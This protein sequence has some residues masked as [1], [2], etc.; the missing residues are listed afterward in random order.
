MK[1]AIQGVKAS[2]H[3]VAA[4]TYFKQTIEPLECATFREL[5]E[6]LKAKKCEFALMAIEN[7]I[8]G[9]I[10]TNYSLLE[11]FHFSIVGEIYLR[12]EMNLLALP[13]EK[14]SNLNFVQ[15]HPMALLQC[16]DFLH[17]HPH[18]KL[19]ESSDTAESAK[20][21]REKNLKG[22][23]AIASR[24]AAETYNLENLAPGIETNKQNYTRFLVISREPR[25][26]SQANKSSLRFE[27][28]HA[29]GSLVAVLKV[30]QDNGINMTKIQSVPILGKP[31][32][33]SFHVD[34]EWDNH[35]S[36]ESALDGMKRK[37][38]GLVSFGNYIRGERPWT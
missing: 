16:E 5:C 31:Y 18:L 10:L 36:I 30:F 3:D 15:S 37:S 19:I 22:Y 20:Y 9:S 21:I 17:G 14:I 32:E 11:S 34:L 24:L 13:G 25:E 38:K 7:S 2:F 27:T 23:G 12:I 6:S 29:P 33:Y 28:G 1:V 35:D 4:R 26:S 8:A